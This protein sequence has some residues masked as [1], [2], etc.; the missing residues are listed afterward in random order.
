MESNSS[1]FDGFS[2]RGF[3]ALSLA[4][5]VPAGLPSRSGAA[6]EPS[7]GDDGLH[8]QDW[9]LQSFLELPEDLA[10]ATAA[11]KRLVLLWEQRGCPYC[12]DLHRINLADAKTAAYIRARFAVL[13]LNLWGDREVTDFDGEKLREKEFARKY[14]INFTPT[15]QFFPETVAAMKGKKGPDAEV[16]RMPGYFRPFHFIS[17]F[18]Y[19]WEKR[20][21][22]QDF[23]RYILEKS[24]AR[25]EI[26]SQKQ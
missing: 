24:A 3:L 11:G 16:A 6:S 10:E 19:V 4:A 22:D 9:F 26:Q 12:H 20:Y 15:L 21:A 1:R 18:E 23:Q 2:R 13:Q 14:R 7:M 25:R 17:M 5:A 8:K